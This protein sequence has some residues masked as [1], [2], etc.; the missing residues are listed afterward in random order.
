M[1]L[2]TGGS[3]WESST[4][5]MGNTVTGGTVKINTKTVTFKLVSNSSADTMY[6]DE[7]IIK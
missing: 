3:N 7:L 1:G 5:A 6:I 4:D 2:L